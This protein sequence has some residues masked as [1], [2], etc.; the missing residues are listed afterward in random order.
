MDVDEC[1]SIL[2]DNGA[3]LG[4]HDRVQYNLE[5]NGKLCSVYPSINC[6]NLYTR[7][8]RTGQICYSGETSSIFHLLKFMLVKQKL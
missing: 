7:S 3:K 1:T 6:C 5:L 8:T 4:Y 2:I